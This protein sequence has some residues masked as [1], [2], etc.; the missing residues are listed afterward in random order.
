MND[1]STSN[2]TTK[3]KL[4]LKRRASGTTS[5]AGTTGTAGT[6]TGTA[7]TGT[8]V[9]GEELT[10]TSS[11]SMVSLGQDGLLPRVKKIKISI[12]GKLLDSDV[13]MGL[14]RPG[15]QE[16]ALKLIMALKDFKQGYL[17]VFGRLIS[18]LTLSMKGAILR[19]SFLE[20]SI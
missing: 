19:R 5:T 4:N 11:S 3:I 6:G 14:E 2:Q 16:H 1:N 20:T 13:W 10:M 7:G 18:N 15:L 9:T 8:A 17:V 12:G